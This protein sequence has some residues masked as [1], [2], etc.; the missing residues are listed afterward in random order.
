MSKIAAADIVNHG[1]AV[2]VF[3]I[4]VVLLGQMFLNRNLP[5]VG[6]KIGPRRVRWPASAHA[7]RIFARRLPGDH[8]LRVARPMLRPT[9]ISKLIC[10]R[11]RCGVQALWCE[12]TA[13]PHVTR[14]SKSWISRPHFSGSTRWKRLHCCANYPTRASFVACI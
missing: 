12:I 4:Y 13:S 8:T 11:L 10:A 7:A 14:A 3:L 5:R 1:P 6:G 9:P 2:L